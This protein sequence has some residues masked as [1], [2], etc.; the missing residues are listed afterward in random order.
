MKRLKLLRQSYTLLAM[1]TRRF[2]WRPFVAAT[3]FASLALAAGSPVRAAND[4]PKYLAC[5]LE[6]GERWMIV[7]ENFGGLRGAV[8]HCIHDLNG[9]PVGVVR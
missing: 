3:V 2:P 9:H 7:I 4:S 5:E 8:A 6:F 1:V